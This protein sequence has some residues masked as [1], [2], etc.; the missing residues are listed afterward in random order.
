M[1]T[2]K[3]LLDTRRAKKDKTFPL[4]F[5]ISVNGPDRDIPTCYSIYTKHWN[6]KINAI[7]ETLPDYEVVYESNYT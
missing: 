2:F 1:A 7:K 3:L 6:S 4:I 5:R